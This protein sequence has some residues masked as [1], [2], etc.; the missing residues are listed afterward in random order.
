MLNIMLKTNVEMLGDSKCKKSGETLGGGRLGTTYFVI[1]I[2]VDEYYFGT[3]KI[4]YMHILLWKVDCI[5]PRVLIE[6][7]H[8]IKVYP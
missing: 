8:F 3:K 4:Q 5:Q 7:L 1:S 2:I 6:H